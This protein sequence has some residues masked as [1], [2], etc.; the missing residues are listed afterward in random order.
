MRT[1]WFRDSVSTVGPIGSLSQARTLRVD[2]GVVE[3]NTRSTQ[4]RL[5]ARSC[6]FESRPRDHVPEIRATIKRPIQGCPCS[7][8]SATSPAP[9][10]FEGGLRCATGR[11][12]PSASRDTAFGSGQ[13]ASGRCDPTRS[14]GGSA[15]RSQTR[16]SFWP[17]AHPPTPRRKAGRWRC[18]GAT[19]PTSS[20]TTDG[21]R[22]RSTTCGEDPNPLSL[23]SS[24]SE[25]A[26]PVD[27]A[28]AR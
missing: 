23:T 3:R 15:I 28:F 6:G 8:A 24:A 16:P 18:C 17:V 22:P 21:S 25:R 5:A 14:I 27:S 13:V 4:N 11:S 2:P 1:G 20:T 12:T 26:T 10:S 7:P 19:V 9:F